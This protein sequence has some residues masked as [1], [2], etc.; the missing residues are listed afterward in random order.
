[1][2]KILQAIILFLFIGPANASD[3][4]NPN[5]FVD[6][7]RSMLDVFEMMQLYQNFSG[8]LGHN[9]NPSRYPKYIQPYS[10]MSPNTPPSDQ[11]ADSRLEGAW[12]SQ[13]RILLAIKQQYA[14][15]Y[16][17]REQYRD[18]YIEIL[19]E[20]LKFK[21]ATTGQ[22]QAFEYRI[23]DDQLALRDDKGQVIQFFRLNTKEPLPDR[24]TEPNFWDPNVN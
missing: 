17:S 15:M 8:N 23:Q 20:H 4:D 19:P 5:P 11:P 7:M 6:M 21:D 14:R 24:E 12:A 10:P 16:W 13:N 2:K 1:M 18:F 3:W 9:P 22:V